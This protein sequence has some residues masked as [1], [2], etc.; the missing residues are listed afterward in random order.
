MILSI[1]NQGGWNGRLNR[2]DFTELGVFYL[3][4][5]NI[6]AKNP[7]YWTNLLLVWLLEACRE[8]VAVD[9]QQCRNTELPW[10][11]AEE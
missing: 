11:V 1:P 10:Q 2:R 3:K 4:V 6:L 7:G 5:F 8:K 9:S